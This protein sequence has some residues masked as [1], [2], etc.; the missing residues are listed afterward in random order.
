MGCC[1]CIYGGG[2]SNV[3]KRKGACLRWLSIRS[4][5]T[6]GGRCNLEIYWCTGQ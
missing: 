4:S 1:C 6:R 5:P 3:G 2:L